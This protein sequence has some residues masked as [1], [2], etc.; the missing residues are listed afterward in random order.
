MTYRVVGIK[1]KR[2]GQWAIE[3]MANR[4]NGTKAKGTRENGNRA[5]GN[6]ANGVAPLKPYKVLIFC[7]I[8]FI[9]M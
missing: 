2:C 8:Y 4:A 7:A 5:N 6:R 3:R 1:S 9:L